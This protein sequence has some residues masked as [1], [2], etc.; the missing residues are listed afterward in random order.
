MKITVFTSNQPRHI[1]LIEALAGVADEVFAVQECGTIFPGETDDFYRRTDVMRDY[2]RRV[3]SAETV[4]FGRPRLLP[5]G[6]RSIAMRMGDLNR[7]EPGALADALRSEVYVVFGSSYIKG[8]L[9]DHLVAHRAVNIHMGVSP[10]YRGSSTNFWAMYDRRPDLVGAT[11]HRLTRGLDSGPVLCHALPKPEAAG[12]FVIGMNAVRAAHRALVEHLVSGELGKLEP[13]EQDRNLEIRYSRHAD[14]DDEVAA[15]Y[16]DRLPTG[17]DMHRA[18][19][20]RNLGRYI[21]PYV[22]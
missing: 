7:L 2:F 11:L 19:A 9:C 6:V 13:L 10:Y 21:R 3:I 4:V 5:A 22:G 1:A 16:L 18:L 20:A 17:E 14:F 12:P 8:A 15:E